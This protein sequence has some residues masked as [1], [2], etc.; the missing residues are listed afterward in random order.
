MNCAPPL[1][2]MKMTIVSSLRAVVVE[3]A[4]HLPEIGVHPV[5]LV[6]IGRQVF[7]DQLRVG[8]EQAGGSATGVVHLQGVVR[9]GGSE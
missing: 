7:A 6:V 8:I 4:Q 5:Y 3:V 2:P 9:R 1:S